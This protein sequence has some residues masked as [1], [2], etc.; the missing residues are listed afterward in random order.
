VQC[1]TSSVQR[2]VRRTTYDVRRA[3]RRAMCDARGPSHHPARG[4]P[5]RTPHAERRTSHRTLHPERWTLHVTHRTAPRVLALALTIGAVLWIAV[6]LLVP[7]AAAGSAGL[8]LLIHDL[9]YQA[10]GRICHQ[11][12]E[13]SFHIGGLQLVVCARCLGLYLGGAAGALAAWTQGLS[14]PSRSRRALLVAAVPTALT[15][16]LEGVGLWLPSNLIRFVSALPLGSAAGPVQ[17][18]PGPMSRA[19]SPCR[20]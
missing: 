9:L 13:R 10:A 14:A 12:P 4:T 5:H 18:C 20:S 17:D 1:S 16:A 2:S 6:L 7:A 11:Q 3:V 15:V 19:V 8:P